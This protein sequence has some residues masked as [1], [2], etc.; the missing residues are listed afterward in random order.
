[1]ESSFKN[2]DITESLKK[3]I[4]L[5][6][7]SR[8]FVAVWAFPSCGEQGPLSSCG[9]QASHVVASLVKHGL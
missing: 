5:F 7:L 4:C 6:W 2:V 3:F 9:L 8:G 1:M